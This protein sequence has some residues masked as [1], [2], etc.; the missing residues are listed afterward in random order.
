MKEYFL[1]V[2]GVLPKEQIGLDEVKNVSFLDQSLFEKLVR[3]N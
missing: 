1:F 2:K 3:E